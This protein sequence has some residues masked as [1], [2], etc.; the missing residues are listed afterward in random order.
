[1]IGLPPS[2]SEAP[3]M[4]SICPP[5]P[6]NCFSPIESATTWPVRSTSMALLMAVT[7]GLR[8]MTAVSLTK[9]MSSMAT[10]GLSS[11]K[12]KSRRVPLTKPATM[13]PGSTTLFSPVMTPRS[14]RSS[15]PSEN[16]SVWMPSLR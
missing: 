1:M 16:I 4:K 5:T 13:R 11:T 15:T 14:T 7:F 9:A 3:R 2:E 10:D 8:R 6:E 12:S